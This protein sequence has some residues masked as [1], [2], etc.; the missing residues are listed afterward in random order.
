M[1]GGGEI[2]LYILIDNLP[3]ECS[4]QTACNNSELSA[5][6]YSDYIEIAR[7]SLSHYFTLL[8]ILYILRG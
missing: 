5:P 3:L 6:K 7:F 4:C 8:E 1:G 2:E